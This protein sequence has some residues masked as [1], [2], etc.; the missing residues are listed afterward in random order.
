M[1]GGDAVNTSPHGGALAA[2]AYGS[3]VAAEFAAS[4]AAQGWA[5]VSGGS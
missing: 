5:A 4:V 1:A 3:Y 2:T